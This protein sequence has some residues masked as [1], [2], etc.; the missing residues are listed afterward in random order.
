MAVAAGS[1]GSG[2]TGRGRLAAASRSSC[3][4]VQTSGGTGSGNSRMSKVPETSEASWIL[5][6]AMVFLDQVETHGG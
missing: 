5:R 4:G 3:S 1:G 6:R 2:N